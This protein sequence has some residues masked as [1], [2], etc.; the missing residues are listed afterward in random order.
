MNAISTDNANRIVLVFFLI[1]LLVF[2]VYTLTYRPFCC[3]V[4]IYCFFQQAKI[5]YYCFSSTGRFISHGNCLNMY[6]YILAER[7][8]L[9]QFSF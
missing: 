3:C 4:L 7:F 9:V 2:C 8:L 6:M 1:G 5:C